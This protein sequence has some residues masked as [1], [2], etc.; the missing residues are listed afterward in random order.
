MLYGVQS[1]K[2]IRKSEGKLKG[3]SFAKAGIILPIPL[4]CIFFLFFLIWRI[5]APPIPNDY[6]IADL[7]SA[8][9]DC[10]ES[11]ELLRNLT[12][13]LVDPR[14]EINEINNFIT[15]DENMTEQKS[16]AKI[17]EDF[18]EKYLESDDFEPLLSM[19]DINIINE[20]T[21]VIKEGTASEI[22]NILNKNAYIIKQAWGKTKKARD[23]IHQLNEFPEIADLYE[24]NRDAKPFNASPLLIDLSRLYMIYAYLQTEIE[25]INNITAELIILDSVY[26]KLSLNGRLLI[27]KLVC[28]TIISN[29]IITANNIANKTETSQESIELLAEHFKPLSKEQLSLKNPLI[30]E[31]LSMKFVV[32]ET[33]KEPTAKIIPVLKKYSTLRLYKNHCFDKLFALGEMDIDENEKLSVWPDFL[34]FKELAIPKASE[35]FTFFY[36][37]YNP[38][39]SLLLK[40]SNLDR[41]YDKRTLIRMNVN[42]MDD[43]LQIVL[44][45]RLGEEIDLT[46]RAYSDEYIIDIENKYILSPGPDEKVGTRDD[47]KLPINPEVLRF[48]N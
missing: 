44:K 37:K 17:P 11:Y 25:N 1:L 34:H 43:L 38:V 21:E 33:L 20:V 39:G 26:K 47:L 24:P 2:K 18:V 36:R 19:E 10:A 46:A 27:T 3:K 35:N 13:L 29:N 5:D 8:P 41:I 45:K 14:E 7:R 22:S 48:K 4:M 12:Y 9:A 32:L 30:F 40:M 23:I 15:F 6:T 16:Q 31:Y 42:I 28:Y